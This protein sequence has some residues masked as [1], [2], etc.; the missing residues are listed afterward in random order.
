MRVAEPALPAE[1]AAAD[2]AI[3]VLFED[4]AEGVE[5]LGG[6]EWLSEAPLLVVTSRPD[7]ATHAALRA[8]GAD[9]S[10]AWPHEAPLF[11][12]RYR[13]LEAHVELERRF[14]AATRAEHEL[15]TSE[16]RLRRLI[17][18]AS[19]S[20]FIKDRGGRYV[21]VNPSAARALGA[22]PDDLIGKTDLEISA[23]V[24]A[25]RSSASTSWR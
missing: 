15:R 1:I 5:R 14:A 11:D 17:E 22:M 9:E 21:F 10:L 8:A 2:G 19:D 4:A 25:G 13:A 20:I 18:L 24:P 6:P 23:S 7:P 3:V 12:A 16:E